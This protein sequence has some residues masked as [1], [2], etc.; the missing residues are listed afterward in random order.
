[1]FGHGFGSSPTLCS[2]LQHT[3]RSMEART[4]NGSETVWNIFPDFSLCW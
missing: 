2:S 4:Q 3:Q 1:M